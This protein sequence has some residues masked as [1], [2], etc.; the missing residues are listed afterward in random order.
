MAMPNDVWDE[1]S[2]DIPSASDPFIQ[3]YMAGRANLIIQEKTTRSD[4]S[5]RKSLSPIAKR[6]CTIVDS[7]RNHEAKTVWT[8][9]VEEDLARN[10]H[11]AIFP[12]MM[13]TMAKERMENTKLWQ[14]VRRMPKGCL[15]HSHMDAMVDFD[16]LL[17]VLIK[18]PGMHM[19]SDR[20]LNSKD[21]LENA[22]MSFRYKAKERTEGSIWEDSYKT[23]SF[24]LLTKAAGAFPD[25]GRQGFLQWLKNRCTLSMVDSHEQHHGIDAIWRKFAKCFVVVDTI[26]H[27]EPIFRSFLQRLMSQLKSDGVNWVELRFT[28]GLNYCRDRKEEPEEDY[29]HM[30]QVIEE[31]VAK[32][33]ASPQGNGFWGLTTIWTTL[34]S[35]DTR[36]M[37]ESMDHCITTKLEFPHLIAGYD[38]VGP[39]DF[40]KPLADVLPELFWFR[41]QCSQE[42][43]NIPFFFHAGETLGD[44]NSTDSNLFDAILL[45]TRRIGHAYSLYKHPLLIDM[46]KEKKIL[47]ESCPISNEVLRLCGSVMAH[48]LPSLLSRGVVCCLCND[49]PAML[50]QDTSGMSHD[51]WQ[52]LQGWDNLGLAGLGSLAENSVRWAAFEDQDAAQWANEIRQASLGGGVKAQRLKEWQIEWEQFCL[53]IVSEFG[54]QFDPE[55]EK[56]DEDA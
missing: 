43:V 56:P 54:E 7:I 26:I 50:G 24:I 9:D 19:S 25:G 47:V 40:G 30:F 41:K 4:A 48:P 12:G 33:K 27:Y 22:A 39:E 20:P 46:V 52:A 21:A 1:I 11:Q 15:L 34:R 44:G 31:E 14:I 55:G 38:L 28:W 51:F 35:V 45:G 16:F 13:F 10:S 32:F 3:Q 42:G 36:P 8:A 29:S 17:D 6:A 49:D 18:T 53:W 5:F 37:I 2:Q 23:E